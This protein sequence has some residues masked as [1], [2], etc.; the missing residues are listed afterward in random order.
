M[1]AENGELMGV[2]PYKATLAR[3]DGTLQIVVVKAGYQS[4]S[5]TLS[6]AQNET[7]DLVLTK[8]SEK[9]IARPKPKS[10]AKRQ[11]HQIDRNASRRL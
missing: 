9:S 11:K 7:L 6:R 5:K 4:Q 3:A 10:P 2:T 8:E 1:N